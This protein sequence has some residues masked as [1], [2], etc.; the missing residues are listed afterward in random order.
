MYLAAL[1]LTSVLASAALVITRL[2]AV[3]P[4]INSFVEA[5]GASTP[6]IMINASADAVNNDGYG[7]DT[8]EDW[9]DYA[10]TR[11][12][13]ASE[14]SIARLPMLRTEKP[15]ATAPAFAKVQLVV[16]CQKDRYRL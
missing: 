11:L 5:K 15:A 12:P 8:I 2:L 9:Q 4:N 1:V 13:W 10:P 7:N 16:R 6:T 3:D 14:L